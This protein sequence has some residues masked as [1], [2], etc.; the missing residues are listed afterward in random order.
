[1]QLTLSHAV[2]HILVGMLFFKASLSYHTEFLYKKCS[3]D[4]NEFNCNALEVT[5]SPLHHA[6]SEHHVD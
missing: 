5:I 1:M 6:M 2:L 3:D 4:M